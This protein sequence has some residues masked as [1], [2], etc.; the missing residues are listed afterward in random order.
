MWLLH[1]RPGSDGGA[2]S[3]KGLAVGWYVVGVPKPPKRPIAHSTAATA[4]LMSLLAE[5]GHTFVTAQAE[6]RYDPE[7]R[8]V[9]QAYIDR[10]Y[11]DR[12]MS[13]MGV[14]A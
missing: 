13:E 10:G 8:A 4:L 7:G 2:V 1:E 5:E 11:G 12:L 3:G 9:C 14:R 6:L